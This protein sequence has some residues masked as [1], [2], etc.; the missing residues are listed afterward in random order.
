[1]ARV[2]IVDDSAVMRMNLKKIL[3]EA[4]HEV[5]AEAQ[6][7]KIACT[8]YEKHQPDFVTMDITM[9]VMSGVDATEA[10]TKQFPDAKI[11]MI[12][13][14]NQKKMVFDALKNGAKHYI[15][16]PIDKM[17]VLS[18]VNEVL[19]TE[20]VQQPAPKKQE[21]APAE[22]V[23]RFE[24]E[25]IDGIFYLR[26]REGFNDQDMAKLA[27]AMLGLLFI[28]PLNMRFDFGSIDRME[29]HL[30]NHLM[31]YVKQIRDGGGDYASIAQ[32]EHLQ[33]ILREKEENLT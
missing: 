23:E 7:G 33:Q 15:I 30:L 31:D 25:N 14:L 4:G 2:M 8:L 26:I 22:Q 17:K 13:A 10:I 12:S 6:N 1:M 20:D 28:K 29:D 19:A 3:T 27:Q 24:I 5:V 18:I 21:E 16:K 9:P 11:I 32:S